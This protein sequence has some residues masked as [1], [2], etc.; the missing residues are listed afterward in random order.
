[1]ATAATIYYKAI[2]VELIFV[3]EALLSGRIAFHS[4]NA[5]VIFPWLFHFLKE[6]DRKY[7]Q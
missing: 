5:Q 1:M 3:R 4:D 7:F 2:E 6:K